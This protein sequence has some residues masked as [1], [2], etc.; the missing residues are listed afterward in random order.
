MDSA[1]HRFMGHAYLAYINR[2]LPRVE[3]ACTSKAAYTTRREARAYARHGRQRDGSL[4]PYHCGHC[5]L[6]HLGH[7][8]GN[9]R[10]RRAT[11]IGLAAVG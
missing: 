3:R 2:A 11:R 1:Q 8:R 5:E 4:A 6:W 9:A 7:N 10:K